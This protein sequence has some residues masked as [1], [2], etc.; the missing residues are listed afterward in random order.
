VSPPRRAA[1]AVLRRLTSAGSQLDESLT[2][3]PELDGLDE[4]DRALAYELVTGTLRR[5]GSCDAVLQ[6]VATAP[7]RIEPA[8]LDILRLGAY[9][10]LFLDRLP[11]YAVV[12]DAVAMAGASRHRRGFVNAVLRRVSTEGEDLLARLAEGEDDHA[13]SVRFSLPEW[14]VAL[15]RR[16]VGEGAMGVLEASVRPPERCVRANTLAAPLEEIESA[17]EAS[18]HSVA[19]ADVDAGSGA[20]AHALLLEGPPIEAG[21]P[22]R[23][24]LVTPQ[25]RGSQLVAPVVASGDPRR[26]LDLA[27]APGVKTAHLA[28]LLP[29]AAI[30]AID[31]D[32]RRVTALERNLRRLRVPI[33]GRGAEA[34]GEASLEGEAMGPTEAEGPAAPGVRV[35]KMDA[36]ELPPAFEGA[37]DAALLD[38]PCTGLGTLATRPDL[39]WRRRP[40]DVERMAKQQRRLLAAGAACVRPGGVLTYAVCTLTRQ[41]T[42]D[43]VEGFATDAEWSFDDLGVRYPRWIH[44]ENG[45]FLRTLP[46][47]DG[48]S[49][50]FIA[51]LRRAGGDDDRIGAAG[52]RTRR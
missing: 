13:L 34:P 14:M 15:L 28:A 1:L 31:V 7:R 43:V 23:D 11:A 44:P 32:A 27:A 46:P 50:F 36:L 16:D 37:F 25:S 5:R 30:V 47:R 9:Q 6:A 52:R 10:L 12:D 48:S 33:V 8:L 29:E 17:L 24:G 19:R 39:R 45:A 21:R 35:L 18:G 3:L 4:R 38:A 41:E 51:R 22:F 49:G 20:L 2:G 40:G 42:L 26:V